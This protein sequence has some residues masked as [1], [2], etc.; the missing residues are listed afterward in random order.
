[1]L[2]VAPRPYRDELLSSWLG[3]IGCRYDLSATQVLDLACTDP[4][5][6]A[7]LAIDQVLDWQLSPALVQGLAGFFQIEP[8]IVEGLSVKARHPG[9][10]VGAFRWRKHDHPCCD[11]AQRQRLAVSYCPSCLADDLDESSEPYFRARWTLAGIGYCP[12]HSSLLVDCCRFCRSNN[13]PIWVCVGGKAQILCPDCRR[14]IYDQPLLAHP[15][16]TSPLGTAGLARDGASRDVPVFP[17]DLN[18]ADA[19]IAWHTL[20]VFDQCINDAWAGVA[21]PEGWMGLVPAD[22]FLHVVQS[23]AVML[24]RHRTYR[25]MTALV[26]RAK[27]NTDLGPADYFEL[28][29]DALLPETSVSKTVY[30]L[31]LPAS[32]WATTAIY[33]MV[34]QLLAA[35]N[36]DLQQS[37]PKPS[38]TDLFLSLPKADQDWMLAQ[39]SAWP[40]ALRLALAVGQKI[41]TRTAAPPTPEEYAC[42]QGWRAPYP[43]QPN[44]NY[45]L[46]IEDSQIARA[47][48]PAIIRRVQQSLNWEQTLGLPLDLRRHYQSELMRR[49]LYDDIFPPERPVRG[50]RIGLDCSSQQILINKAKL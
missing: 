19:D 34:I 31:P 27:H 18:G 45:W 4:G 20:V 3:R 21:P 24:R 12:R 15:H 5:A 14:Y 8:A 28:I 2:P 10:A 49:A 13:A 46:D 16:H 37:R 29:V 9:R 36:N 6:Q 33:A 17:L 30:E 47:D 1:M 43:R 48:Y 50:R 42:A 35:T 22:L 7:A 40:R 25:A 39:S 41:A 38:L 32:R 44:P 11:S 26:T 23:L